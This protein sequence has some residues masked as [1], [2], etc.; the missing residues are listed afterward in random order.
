MDYL[1]NIVSVA[2]QCWQPKSFIIQY[3]NIIYNDGV[4]MKCQILAKVILVKFAK[5][6]VRLFRQGHF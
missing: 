3:R 6:R 4:G 5:T 2:T 1:M